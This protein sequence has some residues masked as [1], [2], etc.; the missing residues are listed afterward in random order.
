MPS[1]NAQ[2]KSLWKECVRHW[3]A[4]ADDYT[5]QVAALPPGPLRFAVGR[6]TEAL[7]SKR[8]WFVA[9]THNIHKSTVEHIDLDEDVLDQMLEELGGQGVEDPEKTIE[10][11][12]HWMLSRLHELGV[13]IGFLGWAFGS[14][15]FDDE[16]DSGKFSVSDG[17]IVYK[18]GSIRGV[19]VNDKGTK[20]I[21]P[22]DQLT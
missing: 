7:A 14:I 21:V 11:A 16:E 9:G 10:M 5:Q 4:Q 13:S 15:I 12:S 18:D 2:A 22:L 6:M 20:R 17:G 8:G 3:K 19:L 1:I